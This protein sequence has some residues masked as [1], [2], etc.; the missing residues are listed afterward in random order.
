MPRLPAFEFTDGNELREEFGGLQSRGDVAALLRVPVSYLTSVLYR[1]GVESYYNRWEISK[2]GGGTREITA[3]RSSLYVLQHRLSIALQS[4]YQ[5]K[6]SVHG[7]VRGRSVVTNAAQHLRKRWVLNVDLQDFYPSLNYGRVRGVLM[8]GPFNCAPEAATVMAQIACVDGVLPTGGPT[9]PVFSNM[10]CMRLDGRLMRLARSHQCWYTRYADDLTVSS[11][12]RSFPE[13]LASR[14]PDAVRTILG[15]EIRTAIE[16]N[17]FSVNDNKTRLQTTDV[18]QAVTGVTVNE[19]LNVDRRYIRLIRAMLHSIETLG[20][21]G[22]QAKLE[23][24]YAKDRWNDATPDLRQVIHGKLAYLQM[25]RGGTDPLLQRY[26]AQFDNLTSGR[27]RLE[28]ID[29]MDRNAK[30]PRHVFIS[31]I[32]EDSSLVDRVAADLE[33]AGLTYWRDKKD[34]P[35]GFHWK[36]AIREAIGSGSV[37]LA[38]FSTSFERRETT[39]MWE[40]LNLAVDQIRKRPDD[41]TWFIPVKLDDCEIPEVTIRQGLNLSDIQASNLFEDWETEMP[42]LIEAVQRVTGG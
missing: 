11:R 31:Y 4:V 23:Q 37:F 38:C 3:P 41:R 6:P 27:H 24:V 18:R 16:E 32:R 2:K 13:E 17:G 21:E 14:D 20:F 19:K 10:I 9:S 35:P 8:A 1:Q 40:E 39:Y 33:D 29:E 25:V 28:G 12:Q 26:R 15:E 7:F 30:Q 22:A 34:L 5:P 42:K 36:V